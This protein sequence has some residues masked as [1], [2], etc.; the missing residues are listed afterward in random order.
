MPN[1]SRRKKEET[2]SN[3]QIRIWN[4]NFRSI[5]HSPNIDYES[6][7]EYC[8]KLIHTF[9]NV[10]SEMRKLIQSST[11]LNVLT[12]PNTLD[13]AFLCQKYRDYLYNKMRFT[14]KKSE[15]VNKLNERESIIDELKKSGKYQQMLEILLDPKTDTELEFCI[16]YFK[17]QD[18][19][20][21]IEEEA[22]AGKSK[23]SSTPDLVRVIAPNI[24]Q[25]EIFIKNKKNDEIADLLYSIAIAQV[26]DYEN[27]IASLAQK[28]AQFQIEKVIETYHGF[29]IATQESL[30]NGI[31][32]ENP[33][34]K[35]DVERFCS[36][37]SSFSKLTKNGNIYQ[38]KPQKARKVK[39][40]LPSWVVG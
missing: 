18:S 19:L 10:M 22:S 4:E 13:D 27:L 37:Q 12:N 29:I 33:F 32:R 17:L 26:T 16:S 34:L 14:I 8:Q 38:P 28:N 5:L 9:P 1:I 3:E 6:L 15:Y 31:S 25:A 35:E 30:I 36:I 11:L 2:M 24:L 21:I 20:K 39:A 7:K 40:K 23:P